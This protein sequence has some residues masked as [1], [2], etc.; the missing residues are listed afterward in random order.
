MRTTR[1]SR[2]H[3][4]LMAALFALLAG[5]HAAAITMSVYVSNPYQVSTGS[6]VSMGHAV[7][8]RT[9]FN[10]LMAGGTYIA[11]CIHPMMAPT[12]GQRTESTSAFLGG[13]SLTV[14]IPTTLPAYIGMPGFSSVER[15]TTV[16][17]TYQWTARAVEG[18]YK[19]GGGGIGIGVGDGEI[20]AGSTKTFTMQ[21]PSLGDEDENSTCIP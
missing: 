20:A 4:G 8:A 6:V 2:R 17:C 9:N 18:G 5:N 1:V 13:L 12:T 3:L 11:Q 10:R 21:V 15:G 7:S 19:I 14:T 16:Y